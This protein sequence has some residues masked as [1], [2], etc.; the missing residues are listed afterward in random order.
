MTV[1]SGQRFTKQRPCP[2]C[3]G[4]DDA[5]RG[6]SRRCFGFLSSD[7]E[8][9]HCTREE[10]AG[11]LERSQSSETFAHRLN[12]TCGCGVLHG[13]FPQ[14]VSR[15]IVATYDYHDEQGS[16]LFQVVRYA[17]KS[18]KQR[19]PDADGGWIWS[20]KGTRRV[21]YRLPELLGSD[22]EAWVFVVEGEKDVDNLRSINLVATTNPGGGGKWTREFGRFFKDRKVAVI[23][24]NDRDG[25]KHEA[26]VAKSLGPVVSDLKVIRLPGLPEKGDVSDWLA[27]GHTGADLMEL[28]ESEKD[29]P[30]LTPDAMN[31]IAEAANAAS[32]R[33]Q[34]D[35]L[36]E[37]VEEVGVKLFTDTTDDTFARIEV[38]GHFETH[39]C[40]SKRFKQ[41]LTRSSWE[42]KHKV[43]NSN[44][45]SSAMN[46]IEAKASYEGRRYRLYNRVAACEGSF[47]Y[48]LSDAKWRAVRIT[49]AGWEVVSRPPVMFRRYA[50]QQPQVEPKCGGDLKRLYDFVNLKMPEHQLLFSVY[51]V[52]CLIPDIPHPIPTL[53]GPQG[54]TKTTALRCG[55]RIVDP[56]ATETLSMPRNPAELVQQLAHHWM[57]IY[58]NIT[59]IPSWISDTLCRATTG[60]GFSKRELYTDDEDIIYSFRRCCGLNG[61]NVAAYQ[62]D[63]LDRCILFGFSRPSRSERRQET[64]LWAEFD[65][66][67]PQLFGAALDALSGAMTI[68]PTLQ[69]PGLP[70]MADFASWGAAIA[71]TLGH[72]AESFLKAYEKNYLLRN[73][74]VLVNDPVASAVLR[75]AEDRLDW[76]GPASELLATL[77]KI[78]PDL[79][80]DTR[81]KGWPKADNALTRRLNVIST[82]LSAVGVTVTTGART[83]GG[84]LVRIE[85][86]SGRTV[87]TVTDDASP[88]TS[89]DTDDDNDDGSHSEQSPPSLFSGENDD[90][91][92][93]DAFSRT[94][95][96]LGAT[97]RPGG[98]AG[99]G[100]TAPNQESEEFEV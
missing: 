30:Q 97:G 28:V 47:W 94:L 64:E 34:A 82:N 90:S 89:T 31:L 93:N 69:L 29:S 24:D 4:Y 75:L 25:R 57:P 13:D 91:D 70:R 39:R 68:Q 45:L 27:A 80:I 81:S 83:S 1:E 84:R 19:R 49:T 54:S 85:K 73:D 87:T 15:R 56:S 96:L 2:I 41:F 95:S 72:S 33:S 17:P 37:L 52:S 71:E 36:V 42:Q 59:F 46:V 40:R 92:G 51:L 35:M 61:I 48:D 50:H 5:P 9:A 38:S 53:H 76:E 67:R 77:G 22:V 32:R 88:T 43:P 26:A 16:L 44:A 66:V 14:S 7:R 98:G 65:R 63:L 58:D 55:R 10:I 100:P 20:L 62:P 99:A 86:V 12:G 23:G 3:R 79:N 60:D 18:F 6:T 8:Y 11:D 78:A 21:P 74:E